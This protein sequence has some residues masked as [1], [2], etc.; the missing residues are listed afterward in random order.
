MPT[1]VLGLLTVLAAGAVALGL[2]LAPATPDLTVHNGAGETLLAPSL[3]AYY[4]SVSPSRETVRVQ[5]QAP[6][7]MT[8]T[9]LA[10][11]PGSRPLRSRTITGSQA[12]KILQPFDQLLKITGF[13]PAGGRFV[14]QQPASTLVPAAEASQVSGIVRYDVQVSGGYVVD[15]TESY[16][17]T[18][19]AGAQRGVYRYQVTSVGGQPV[20]TAGG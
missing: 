7:R 8:E 20:A 1:L 10:A 13:T 3:T 6:D 11:G 19:P 18:T 4:S 2:L 12:A 17:V 16:R 9:L 14:G 15:V 5:Y